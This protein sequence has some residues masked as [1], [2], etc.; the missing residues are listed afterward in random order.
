MAVATLPGQTR[1]G[2][3]PAFQNESVAARSV[4]STPV[5]MSREFEFSGS[6]PMNR[7]CV[8]PVDVA[9]WVHR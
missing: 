7:S 5:V 3:I 6:L 8:R 4:A 9:P 2:P 1:T